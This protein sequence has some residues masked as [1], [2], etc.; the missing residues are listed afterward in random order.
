MLRAGIARGQYAYAN[1]PD[2]PLGYASID[3]SACAGF[4]FV[5]FERPA[6]EIHSVEIFSD[7]YLE[8]PDEVSLAAWE[9]VAARIEA[10]DP[11]KVITH[12]GV[13][14]SSDEQLFDD[15]TVI[16]LTEL[17]GRSR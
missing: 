1:D 12:W 4:G 13:K 8:L 7:G 10:E 15:R 9:A 14:G 11:G 17:A 3:G 5:S 6:A 2:H 16:L